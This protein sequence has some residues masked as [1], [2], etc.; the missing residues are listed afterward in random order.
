VDG[1]QVLV[2]NYNLLDAPLTQVPMNRP[3]HC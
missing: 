2:W 1:A 3:S